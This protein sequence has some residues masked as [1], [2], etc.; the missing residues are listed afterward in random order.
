MLGLS[1]LKLLAPLPDM[2]FRKTN[3]FCQ[4]G[5]NDPTPPCTDTLPVTAGTSQQPQ[6]VVESGERRR[7]AAEADGAPQL[8]TPSG[9]GG[10]RLPPRGH[11]FTTEDMAYE[12]DE[13]DGPALAA[14]VRAPA[15]D[16]WPKDEDGRDG[17][18]EQLKLLHRQLDRFMSSDKFLGVYEMLGRW[19]R[20]QGGTAP[21]ASSI[22]LYMQ[23]DGCIWMAC[24]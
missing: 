6:V 11:L 14:S 1:Q 16:V 17:C 24:V 8:V 18:G 20:R 21:R 19:E 5:P 2:T 9:C 22:S 23:M 3:V 15:V 12:A 4:V 10:S 7:A 13:D